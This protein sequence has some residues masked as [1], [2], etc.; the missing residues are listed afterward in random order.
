[1][2]VGLSFGSVGDIIAVC[3]LIVELSKALDDATG[4]AA[5]YREIRNELDD[6]V[7]LLMQVS[8]RLLLKYHPSLAPGGSGNVFKDAAKKL[9]FHMFDRNSLAVILDQF[10]AYTRKITF[11]MVAALRKTAR[12]DSVTM[13][14]RVQQVENLIQSRQDYL[15]QLHSEYSSALQGR[16]EQLHRLEENLETQQQ[17]FV[18][19]SLSL[20]NALK[21]LQEIKEMLAQIANTLHLY[22]TAPIS[23]RFID[24]TL[25]KPVVLET[26]LG[27]LWDIPTNWIH[28]W[29]MFEVLLAHRFENR[30]GHSMVLRKQFALEESCSGADIERH[31]PWS[32]AIRPGM[33]INMSM[34]FPK[35]SKVLEKCPRCKTKLKDLKRINVEW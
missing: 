25:G 8:D 26:S 16:S 6:F 19:M 1:M 30:R 35:D 33:K 13:L 20:G 22:I 32:V 34:V 18:G 9:Q 7:S 5:H 21:A 2:D 31:I 24:P 29:D 12:V 15:L 23:F 4:S 10:A 17:H 27:E 11:L 14:A 3:Q 28:E